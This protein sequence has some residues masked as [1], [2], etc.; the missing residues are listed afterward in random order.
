MQASE[1]LEV[2]AIE[3]NSPTEIKKPIIEGLFPLD[4]IAP[5]P[6]NPRKKFDPEKLNELA[7][8]IRE[9]GIIQ[10]LVAV[11]DPELSTNE[12]PRYRLV[13]GERRLKAAKIAGLE[14]VPV[15]IVKI[16][17][18]QEQK[19]MLIENLQREDLDALEEARAFDVLTKQ[20]GWK[21]SELAKE[22]G[23]SQAHI[24]NR[25]RLLKLPEEIKQ[26]ISAG[27]IS[28]SVGKELVAFIKVP[29]VMAEIQ[30]EVG[31]AVRAEIPLDPARLLA[32]AKNTAWNK[33]KPLH[34]K[35]AWPEPEFDLKPCEECAQRASLHKPYG[36]EEQRFPRCLDGKCWDRKQ[37][38]VKQEAQ[39]QAI[40]QAAAQ[41]GMDK[42]GVLLLDNM[43]YTEFRYLHSDASSKCAGCEH[44][45]VGIS[46]YSKQPN[47]VCTNPE[48]LEAMQKAQREEV[49]KQRKQEENVFWEWKDELVHSE[50]TDRE[51][52]VLMAA[53]A[54]HSMVS[55]CDDEEIDALCEHFGWDPL[56]DEDSS[57]WITEKEARK[58]V[59]WLRTL[60]DE[61]LWWV[62]RY[63]LIKPVGIADDVYKVMFGRGEEELKEV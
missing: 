7:A 34:K 54:V 20:Y 2:K 48:C 41:A 32:N 4:W 51:T 44:K 40:E 31:K 22:L 13:A 49:A 50:F 11:W 25:I 6:L 28:H 18:E 57:N 42:D 47:T 33:T 60:S 62:V 61:D 21:Q 3:T 35:D 37:K 38:D 14:K 43:T 52:L 58:I 53:T 56:F 29:G 15:E 1:A 17:P 5:N 30:K 9:V 24:A 19:I 10:P 39:A 8:S 27:I 45:K 12:V 63:C 16:T 46:R 59:K 26:N 55:E 36:S 23:V